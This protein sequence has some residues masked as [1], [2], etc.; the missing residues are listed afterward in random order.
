VYPAVVFDGVA[1]AE[2]QYLA[3]VRALLTGYGIT[4]P[5]A[6][7]PAGQFSDATVQA[8]YDPLVAQ[9]QAS[10]SAAIGVAQQVESTD[11][12][13]LRDALFGLSAADVARLYQHLLAASQQHLAAFTT[14]AIR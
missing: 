14:W 3:A 9:G 10:Q 5:T 8:S 12:A 7:Q 1:V 4:D 11:I 13:D 6:G 2:D